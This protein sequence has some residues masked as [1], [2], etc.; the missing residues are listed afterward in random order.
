MSREHVEVVRA[1][2]EAVNRRDFTA[3][4]D[5]YAEGAVLVV[6][7]AAVPTSAGTFC[8]RET[9]GNWFGDWFRSFAGDYRF[10][11]EEARAVGGRVLVTARH[12]GRGRASG[13]VLDWS[14]AYIYDV[15]AG[16][17]ARVEIYAT[18]ADALKALGPDE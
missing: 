6:D 12:H 8:G 3:A 18:R 7:P 2:F 5:A 14:L 9:I 1:Q 13:V 15:R 16:K 11:I 17:V 4:M 10:D